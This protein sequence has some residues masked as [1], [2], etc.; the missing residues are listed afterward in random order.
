MGYLKW[1]MCVG[2]ALRF[3]RPS[4]G[5]EAASNC[6]HSQRSVLEHTENPV[7][8]DGFMSCKC[9]LDFKLHQGMFKN[10]SV[11]HL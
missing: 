7:L 2:G 9:I 10:F 11:L 4:R 1:G 3:Q 6:E 8:Q 5:P